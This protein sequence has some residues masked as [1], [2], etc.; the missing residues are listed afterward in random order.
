MAKV[1]YQALESKQG[2]DIRVLDIH[3]VSVLADYF[4]IAHGRNRSHVQALL[5]EVEDKLAE[6]G[7]EIMS[8]EGME[9]FTW[10]LLD[11]NRIIVH[12][13]SEEARLFYNL[14]RIWSDGK[15]IDPSELA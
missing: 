5:D 4:V 3:D 12:I 15:K 14:E 1:A 13:F 9:S 8:K 11:C 2:E 7:Y 10:G 6:A